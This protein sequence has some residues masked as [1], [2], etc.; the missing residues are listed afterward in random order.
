MVLSFL[1]LCLSY[2]QSSPCSSHR[3]P[4]SFQCYVLSILSQ[5]LRFFYLPQKLLPESA[6]SRQEREERHSAPVWTCLY[7]IT[8]VAWS[9]RWDCFSLYIILNSTSGLTLKTISC[10]QKRCC[11]ERKKK[12]EM[13]TGWMKKSTLK[14]WLLVSFYRNSRSIF[15]CSI[16]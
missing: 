10:S 14:I 12:I 15:I 16:N 6:N 1:F 8:A 5:H 11:E 9:T 4:N 7:F 3:F 2:M 13:T